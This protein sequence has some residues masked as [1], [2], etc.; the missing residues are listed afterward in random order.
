MTNN[1]KIGLV[2]ITAIYILLIL[3]EIKRKKIQIALSTFWL[4]S[5]ILLII[6]ILIPNLVENITKLL[7]FEVPAN[8]LF[9]ITIFVA[10]Y[11]IFQLTMRVSK[12]YT[13]NISLV[14]EISLLK[15][16]VNELE[17]EKKDIL[18]NMKE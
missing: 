9:C 11:L 14:Q 18:R 7:G 6:A 2:I 3:K 12:V 16:R 10:F 5:G 13:N 8:M 4:T 15:N 17:K 1:L